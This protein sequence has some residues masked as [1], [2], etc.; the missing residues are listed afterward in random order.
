MYCVLFT[1]ISLV[2]TNS[3]VVDNIL[4]SI[5]I[6]KRVMDVFMFADLVRMPSIIRNASNI[7][8]NTIA[9]PYLFR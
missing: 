2:A 9:S 6:V 5:T 7:I 4:Q 3:V 1:Y 8:Y